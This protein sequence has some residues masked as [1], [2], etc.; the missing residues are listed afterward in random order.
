MI[1][2]VWSWYALQNVLYWLFGFKYWVISIEVPKIISEDSEG[3]RKKKRFWTEKRYKL[4]ALIGVVLNVVIC[5]GPGIMRGLCNY[6]VI[7]DKGV[8]E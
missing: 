6:M 3:T 8:T 4:F 5:L 2:G 1:G 7:T